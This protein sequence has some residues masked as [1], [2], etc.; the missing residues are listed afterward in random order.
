MREIF[1]WQRLTEAG[2]EVGTKAAI[3]VLSSRQQ[4][5]QA[6]T[7]YAQAKYGYLNNLVALRVAAGNL[8]RATIA[9]INAWLVEPPDT[10]VP[11]TAPAPVTAPAPTD[12]P[13]PVPPPA[14]P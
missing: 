13:A 1:A 7:N 3:D 8:D 10:E 12:A 2:Y 11:A 9:Q 5:V 6:Q 14:A 4:F